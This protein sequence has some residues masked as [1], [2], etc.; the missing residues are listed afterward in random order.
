MSAV[1]IDLAAW[2]RAEAFRLFRGY[3][4]PH[5]AVTTRLD[6]GRVMARRA[7]G[8]SPFR[9]AIHA[10]GAGVHAVPALRTR[11]RGERVVRHDAVTLSPT[12]P[13][14][15]GA[16]RYAYL[17]W[18]PRFAEFDAEAAPLIEAARAGAALDANAGERDDLAHLSCLPWLDFTALDNALPSPEDCIPRI[19]WGKI[20]AVRA[21][22]D[23]AVALQV[24][25]ALAHGRDVGLFV[26]AVQAALDAH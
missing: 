8:L 14:P 1:E 19:S 26:E 12:I 15:D 3:D 4:R 10:I 23:M 7:A 11:F 17:S 6:M 25:H 24:H 20:V 22:H 9:A 16:F 18:H 5:Y 2:E 13:M 21:G